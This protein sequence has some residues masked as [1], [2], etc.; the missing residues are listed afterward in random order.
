MLLLFLPSATHLKA[1][2]AWN[3][4]VDSDWFKSGNWS[5]GVPNSGVDTAIN[6]LPGPLLI[7]TGAATQE[8]YIGE[9]AVGSLG[10]AGGGALTSYRG[11]IGNQTG[12]SGTVTVDDSQWRQH[13]FLGDNR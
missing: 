3:G 5:A 4:S 12:S 9:T 13:L 2:T 1:Q 11:Y 6:G 8:V 10:I 7:T